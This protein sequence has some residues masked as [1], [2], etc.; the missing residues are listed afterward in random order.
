MGHPWEVVCRKCSCNLWDKLRTPRQV[1]AATCERTDCPAKAPPVGK[2]RRPAGVR[3]L[4]AAV[5]QALE[6]AE[7]RA[8]AAEERM[9]EVLGNNPTRVEVDPNQ[10]LRPGTEGRRSYLRDG[11]TVRFWLPK[12]SYVDVELSGDAVEVKSSWSRVVA[13]LPVSGNV[14]RVKVEP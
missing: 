10:H 7:E 4:P 9:A 3:T 1:A 14:F 6:R 12:G 13:L 11:T 8:R 2:A 5:A